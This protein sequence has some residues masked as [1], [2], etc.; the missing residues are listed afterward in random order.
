MKKVLFSAAVAVAAMVLS[1]CGGSQSETIIVKGSASKFDS[2][3]YAL[4]ANIANDVT[5]QMSDMPFDYQQIKKGFEDGALGGGDMTAED[6]LSELQNYF[7]TVRPERMQIVAQKRAEADS[8]AIASGKTPEQVAADNA[9]LKADADMFVDEAQRELISYSFGL[10]LGD[11]IS[12]SEL[13]IH[14]YW[15]NEA[16]QNVLDADVKM[17]NDEALAFLQNYF[18][19]VRP[20]Q[21]KALSE[22]K[23]AEVAKMKGVIKTE[24]GLLYRIESE[25]DM[26]VK[27]N[28]DRDVIKVNYT[29]R[30]MRNGNVFDTSRFAD[31]TDEQ[32]AALQAQ[33]NEGW[34]QDQPI[35][36]PLNGVIK[37]WTE[38]MKF[39]GK[40]GS[41]T[42]WIPSELAYGES[43]R[44]QIQ[45]NDAL[46]FFVEVVDVTPFEAPAE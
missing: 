31:R 20:A 33:G 38:G 6:A 40:G 44:G 10:N 24:S 13:P 43:A 2:L 4:G 30:L 26:S 42:L 22:E 8:I 12:N 32:K 27:A 9:L 5:T 41:I 18:T 11:N 1:S 39:V 14:V 17:T 16:I 45:A 7:M 46:E 23:L 25:G 36:F 15:F 35:E 29:G 37:G 28:D 19:V 3:S 34:D 21:M